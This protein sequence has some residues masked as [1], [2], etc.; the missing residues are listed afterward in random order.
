MIFMSP[1]LAF[2]LLNGLKMPLSGVF[3]IA[4]F[5]V[6]ILKIRILLVCILFIAT[7]LLTFDFLETPYMGVEILFFYT[8]DRLTF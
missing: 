3:F 5:V 8:T 2:S 7:Y 6:A 1:D 4:H